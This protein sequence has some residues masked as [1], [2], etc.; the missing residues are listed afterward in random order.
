MWGIEGDKI[1][2]SPATLPQREMS[3][4]IYSPPS[5][6]VIRVLRS[7][8]SWLLGCNLPISINTPINSNTQYSRIQIPTDIYTKKKKKCNGKHTSACVYVCVWAILMS[9][10]TQQQL[11]IKHKHVII[12]L[13]TAAPLSAK[14]V[15]KT[16]CT[17]KLA[18]LIPAKTPNLNANTLICT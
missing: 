14:T 16:T 3:F 5:R 17:C 15:Y 8:G 11:R 7:P 18:A 4:I 9:I 1:S 2:N 12:C 13:H 6:I 10:K